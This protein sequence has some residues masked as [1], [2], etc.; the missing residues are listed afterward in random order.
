MSTQIFHFIKKKKKEYVLSFPFP[1]LH[2]NGLSTLEFYTISFLT[3]SNLASIR[4][5]FL[6]LL[7]I[8]S[9]L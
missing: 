6:S 7:K 8:T 9:G 5:H 1:A 3:P 4:Q 2:K